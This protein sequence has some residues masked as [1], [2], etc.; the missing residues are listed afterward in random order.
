MVLAW[1]DHFGLG[2]MV[3]VRDLIE[4]ATPD[5]FA[6]QQPATSQRLYDALL[7]VAE[8][9]RHRG[10]ISNDRL[11]RWLSKVNGKFEQGLRIVR[12]GITAR[13]SALAAAS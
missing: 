8:D 11:G 4:A 10:S 5:Q 3:T 12:A 9:H 6:L 1:R 7:A 13:L 2:T